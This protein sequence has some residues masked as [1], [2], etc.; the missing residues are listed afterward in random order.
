MA[1]LLY[2][3]AKQAFF[4]GDIDVVVNPIK[5]LFVDST[6]SPNISS[7]EFVSNV[8]LSAIKYRSIPLSNVTANL[9]ILDADNLAIADYP[10][11]AFKALIIYQDT[12]NDSTSRLIAYI[13]DS[14]GLPFPGSGSQVTM[15]IIWNND[16]N[17]II[18]LTNS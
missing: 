16:A 8:T 1:N 11:D 7:D 3:K 6:Y 12:G 10:G 9:G 14:V 4:N 5:I 17:K 15:S 2:G 13:E 18:A